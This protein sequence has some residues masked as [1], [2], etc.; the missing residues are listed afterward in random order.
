MFGRNLVVRK[1]SITK[2]ELVDDIILYKV[3]S[4]TNTNLK[5]DNTLLIQR[6]ENGIVQK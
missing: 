2:T 6:T 1:L 5:D 4:F 3:N